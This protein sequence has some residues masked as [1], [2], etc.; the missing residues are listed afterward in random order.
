MKISASRR[1]IVKKFGH[2]YNNTGGNDPLELMG[3]EGVTYFNNCVVAELQGCCWAQTLLI[4]RLMAEGIIAEGAEMTE[5][6]IDINHDA[7]GV[8]CGECYGPKP[9]DTDECPWMV[10]VS[11]FDDVD[12]HR[13]PECLAA[14]G[15]AARLQEALRETL[16]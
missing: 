12:R 3:R 10:R 13:G 15:R 16:P 6:I 11:L 14:A 8:R 7:D 9:F 1:K 4:E 5:I 2:L